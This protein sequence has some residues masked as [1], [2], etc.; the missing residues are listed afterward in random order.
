G[1]DYFRKEIIGTVIGAFTPFYA[2]GAIGAHWFGGYVRD[3][4]GS[5]SIPFMVAIGLAATSAVLM[6]F[7]K[8]EG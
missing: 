7:V 5:F 8:K 3:V 6:G 2:F 4:T 1:G